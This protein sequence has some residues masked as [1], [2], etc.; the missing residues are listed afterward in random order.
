VRVLILNGASHGDPRIREFVESEQASLERE[1]FDVTRHDL[2]DEGIAFCQGCFDCWVKTPGVCKTH[3]DANSISAAYA[4]SDVVLLVSPILFG[5][6]GPELK[7]A[8]D[9]SIGLVSPF[10]E[11]VNGETHHMKRYA[12]Y[13]A[14][15]TVGFLRTTDAEQAEIFRALAARHALNFRAPAFACEIVEPGVERPVSVVPR[16]NALLEAQA[17]AS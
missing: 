15:L 9:R 17:A 2:A 7:K 14:I 16:V 1:G 5:G 11:K 4:A 12:R 3:D 13:P 8:L 6:Y 10:F